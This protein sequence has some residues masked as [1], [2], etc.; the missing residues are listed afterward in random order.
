MHASLQDGGSAEENDQGHLNNLPSEVQVVS[1]NSEQGNPDQVLFATNNPRNSMRNVRINTLSTESAY[2]HILFDTPAPDDPYATMARNFLDRDDEGAKIIRYLFVKYNDFVRN[3]IHL[4]QDRDI[5]PTGIG[6]F[7]PEYI[8]IFYDTESIVIHGPLVTSEV[9]FSDDSDI[10]ENVAQAIRDFAS[11]CDLECMTEPVPTTYS[12]NISVS[13]PLVLFSFLYSLSENGTDTN[14]NSHFAYSVRTS[15]GGLNTNLFTGKKN[16]KPPES[17]TSTGFLH[18]VSADT[19]Q[20]KNANTVSYDFSSGCNI[21]VRSTGDMPVRKDNL[22]DSTI[23]N[24]LNKESTKLSFIAAENPN[25]NDTASTTCTANRRIKQL[26]AEIDYDLNAANKDILME[27]NRSTTLRDNDKDNYL[28]QDIKELEP[29][30]RE[31]CNMNFPTN[32]NYDNSNMEINSKKNEEEFGSNNYQSDGLSDFTLS[33][34]SWSETSKNFRDFETSST[35]SSHSSSSKLSNKKLKK[36]K[37]KKKSKSGPS[38]TK[39]CAQS[40]SIIKFLGTIIFYD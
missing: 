27:S 14:S 6:Y 7:S 32:K 40:F 37:E 10:F 18:T 25:F 3:K 1:P 26:A 11:H 36:K 5:L 2:N 30:I 28:Y 24:N 8:T 33:D 21:S 13:I 34:E 31:N 39:L 29:K 15:P 9:S 23:N 22:V 17:I 38:E 19:V 20:N 35:N 4:F 12:R 16:I